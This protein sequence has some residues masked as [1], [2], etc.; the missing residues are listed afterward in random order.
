AALEND[1]KAG[2]YLDLNLFKVVGNAAETQITNSDTLIDICIKLPTELIN[3]D[4]KVERSYHVIRLHNGEADII[5]ASYN[6]ED[7]TLSFNSDKFS[8]YAVSYIDEVVPA[9]NVTPTNEVPANNVTPTNE[10][11]ANNVAPTNEVPANDVTP[12]QVET[13]S[14]KADEQNAVDT[15]SNKENVK[16][17]GDRMPIAVIAMLMLDSVMGAIYLSLRR[18]V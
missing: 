17:T 12:A 10:V 6:K 13:P 9:N 7:G 18:R 14:A 1:E 16:D 3:T 2:L 15:T 8:I 4:D 5:E 11:P